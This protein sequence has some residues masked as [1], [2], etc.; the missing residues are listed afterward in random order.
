MGGLTGPRI[1]EGRAPE[2]DD[3]VAIDPAT[4]RRGGYAVGEDV[5]VSTPR[6]PH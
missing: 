4:V 5:R 6:H 3:E 1:V 2:A